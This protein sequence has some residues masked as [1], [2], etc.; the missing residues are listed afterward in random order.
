MSGIELALGVAGVAP[1]LVEAIRTF[2][3]ISQ[4]VRT[5]RKCV[6][7]LRDIELDLEIQQGRFLN[8]SIF[9][10]QSAGEDEIVCRRMVADAKHANWN[11]NSLEEDIRL[12]LGHS[13]E[14]C[15][16][17]IARTRDIQQD[18]MEHL[19]G[20]EIVQSHKESVSVISLDTLSIWNQFFWRR[21]KPGK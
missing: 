8:E 18:V 6:K 19:K 9:L 4:C 20:F 10:L 15:K 5:A 7:N 1:V 3:K 2:M 21:G 11:D 12:R 13:Y 14:L 17:I 16:R